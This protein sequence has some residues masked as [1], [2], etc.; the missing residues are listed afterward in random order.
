MNWNND[1][2]I[3]NNAYFILVAETPIYSLCIIVALGHIK[4]LNLKVKQ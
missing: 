2:E 1:E 4:R 3:M